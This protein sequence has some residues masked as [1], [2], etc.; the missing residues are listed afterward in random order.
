VLL[1]GI[2]ILVLFVVGAV[3]QV[4][5][6]K[7]MLIREK[8][9]L[10]NGVSEFIYHIR[11]VAGSNG[12]PVSGNAGALEQAQLQAILNE[13]MAYHPKTKTGELVVA[14]REGDTMMFLLR[15]RSH[16]EEVPEILPFDSPLALPMHNA[17][18]G[19]SGTLIGTDYRGVT[20]VAAYAPV[21]ELGIGVVSKIDLAEIRDP[22]VHSGIAAGSAALLLAVIVS[23]V[24]MRITAPIIRHIDE[25]EERYRDV[26]EN[27]S[28]IVYIFDGRGNVKFGNDAAS[29]KLGYSSDE[30]LRLNTKMLLTPESYRKVMGIYRAQIDGEEVGPFEI[31]FYGKDGT[32]FTI[33]SKERVI[34]H[35][36]KIVEI[37]GIGRDITDR[38]QAQEAL[39]E[40]ELKYRNMIMNLSEGFYSAT[41]D[42]ILL[43][44]NDEFC[45]LLGLDP[46]EDLAGT[47]LPDFWQDPEDRKAYVH[48][49]KLRGFVRNRLATAKKRSGEK[50]FFE[51]NARIIKATRDNRARIEGSFIDVTERKLAEQALQENEERY[52]TTLD[53][54]MEGCQIVGPDWRYQYLNDAAVRHGRRPRSELIGLTMMEAYPGIEDTEVFAA[55][56]ECMEL[57]TF[58][59]IENKFIYPD[60]TSGWFSLSIEPVPEGL[61]VLSLDITEQKQA[62]FINRARIRLLESS[63]SQSLDEFLTATLDEIEALTGSSIGFYHFLLNDQKTLSLQSWSTNTLQNM[64]TAE[65][66]GSH[67]NIDEP[68]LWVDCVR[69]RGPVI[70]NDYISLSHRRGLPEGHA[71]VEREVVVPVF[72]GGLITAIIGVGNKG[73]DYTENDVKMVSQLGDMSWDIAERKRAEE[74]VQRSMKFLDSMIDQSPVPMWISDEYGALIRINDACCALMHITPG[75]VVGIYNVFNDNIVIEQGRLPQVAAV[76]EK[77]ETARFELEYDTN[78]VT[79]LDLSDTAFVYLDVTIFPVKNPAGKITNAVIQHKDITEKKRADQVLKESEVKYR[80]VA[81]YTY[82]WEYWVATDGH[83]IYVSPACE[84]ITGYRAEEFMANPGLMKAI[85]HPDDVETVK[86]HEAEVTDNKTRAIDFRII[87]KNGEERWIAHVCQNVFGDDGSPIGRR[88]GNRDITE[89][90]RGE[91]EIRKLNE[92]LEQRVI[93]RTAQLSAANKE[94]EAFSYSV[95]HDL[96]SPLRAIDGFTRVLVEEYDEKLDDEGKR[97]TGIIRDNTVRMGRLIDD[98]LAFSRVGRSE[99]HFASVNMEFLARSVFVDLTSEEER[100]RIDFIV[101]ALPEADGDVSL[102]R[103]VWSNLVSNAVKFSSKRDRAVIDVSSERRDN[104]V[105]YSIR[106]NGA[107]FDMRYSNKLFGVFQRLHGQNEF[108]GTGVGLAI[109]QRVIVRHG[110]RVWAEGEENEGAVFHFSLPTKHGGSQ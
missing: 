62:E 66:K 26:L 8:E 97:L 23:F 110:G 78:K 13:H 49:L 102:F 88:G 105:V 18:S 55:L 87:N 81:D 67:Y 101:G 44:Y 43:E 31:D 59:Q 29:R 25:S 74:E 37:H 12:I 33:E 16:K 42:G 77:G 9:R 96:R 76:F 53:G 38:K 20:V 46:N 21:P 14:R 15:S 30:L 4:I 109:V 48:E 73:A 100:A 108:S 86:S 99:L 103:Q 3:S 6:Y 65:G 68:G 52:R 85:I 24:F 10:S 64:C 1:I 84:R 19:F 5:L 95:S 40:S 50:R 51:L 11:D 83:L 70:H 28:D 98:L 27:I 22:F 2:M 45:R 61:F 56:K 75:E 57:R 106:D 69:E 36:K 92:E 7:T 72:R 34:R 71:P 58:R 91:A 79:G 80:T 90:K 17:L 104:E 41:L 60:G 82:D 39:R 93:D 63:I 89:R 32:I 107:G 94:L 47:V 35:G 54:M